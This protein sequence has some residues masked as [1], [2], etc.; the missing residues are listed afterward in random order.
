MGIF[1]CY[2]KLRIE[3]LP[4]L[5][6]APVGSSEF[7]WLMGFF[8][9]YRLDMLAPAVVYPATFSVSSAAMVPYL[10][11]NMLYNQFRT[12]ENRG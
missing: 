12:L 8:C 5:I 1:L 10:L 2:G 6:T 7:S 11:L 9:L 3:Q 4:F